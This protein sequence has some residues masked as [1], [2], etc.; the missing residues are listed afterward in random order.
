MKKQ[1]K[2]GTNTMKAKAKKRQPK[3]TIVVYGRENDIEWGKIS[4][5]QAKKIIKSGINEDDLEDLVTDSESLVSDEIQI[6]VNDKEVTY[7][8]P[9]NHA[10]ANQIA[11]PK[12]WII[13]NAQAA[14]GELG[15]LVINEEFD[16]TKLKYEPDRVC[17]GKTILCEGFSISYDGKE[18]DFQYSDIESSDWAIYSP[19]GKQFD[20]DISNDDTEVKL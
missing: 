1:G 12:S 8:I 9:A 2:V 3:T 20:F 18:L 16:P 13:V 11:N 15:K 5:A 10:R 14:N 17:I 7:D 6:L 19:Q 4:E